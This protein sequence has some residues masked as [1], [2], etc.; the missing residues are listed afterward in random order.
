[1]T[2]GGV[3]LAGYDLTEVALGLI[4]ITLPAWGLIAVFV[5][6]S[7]I[8]LNTIYTMSQGHP[9]RLNAFGAV[10]LL[11]LLDKAVNQP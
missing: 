11:Y 6:G 4:G 2:T 7:V 1:M 5:V 10:T 3:S 9:A 8:T